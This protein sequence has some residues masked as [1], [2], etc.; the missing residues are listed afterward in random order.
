M[1]V[2]R[3]LRSLLADAI[4]APVSP[5]PLAF[6]RIAFAG[7][8]LAEV[9]HFAYRRD[10][11]FLDSPIRQSMPSGIIIDLW[12][13]LFSIA[14]LLAGFLT[15]LAAVLNYHYTV[16]FFAPYS[17]VSYHA[18]MLYIP[19][20]LLLIFAPTYRCWS[21]DRL[22]FRRVFN[23]DIAR[24][25]PRVYQTAF[26]LWVMGFMYFDSTVYKLESRFW[27]D[28]L[29]F[30]LPASFPS[31]TIFSW[32]AV[33]NQK[34]LMLAAGYIT[35]F[36][37][38]AFI[39]LFW[40]PS[41]RIYLLI[42]GL[43]LHFGIAIVFPIPLFGL[44]MVAL[45]INLLPLRSDNEQRAEFWPIDRVFIK[46]IPSA[47]VVLTILQAGV[48]FN[49][50]RAGMLESRLGI[51]RHRVFGYWQFGAMK[52][53]VALVF[54]DTSQ[55]ETWIPWVNKD[56]HVGSEAYGRFWSSWWLNSLPDYEGQ[57]DFWARAAESWARRN[58]VVLEDGE[59]IV[60]FK[61]LNITQTWMANRHRENES[62]PW[63][64]Y[65]KI[66]WRNAERHFQGP[67]VN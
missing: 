36:Y 50:F 28:G 64:D 22:W 54:R 30:W 35:L 46:V 33:L 47:L 2:L 60:K 62:L 38:A 10:F 17:P 23:I 48:T 27:L 32:N 45:L 56:G 63:T 39:F 57:Q 44:L 37:E 65:L 3:N 67:K 40:L 26:A 7:V 6:F 13:W 15:P 25:V 4:S 29:G 61:T 9:L 24:P 1:T 11:I 34:Y 20:A 14:A 16:I 8:M 49:L 53:D 31:F 42:V 41:A 58:G 52:H 51:A 43:I 59:V 5:C 18:D 12:L 66:S 19:T 21:V 55:R